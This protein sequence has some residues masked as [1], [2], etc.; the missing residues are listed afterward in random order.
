MDPVNEIAAALAAAQAEMQNPGFDSTNPHFK[1]KFASLAAVRKSVVPVFA[2]HGISV[3]QALTTR[4]AVEKD[5]IF[6]DEKVVDGVVVM[7]G[8]KPLYERSFHDVNVCWV[9]CVVTLYHASGQSIAFPPFEAPAGDMTAQGV[10]AASTYLRRY[11]LQSIAGVV[12]DDDTDGNDAQPPP[13]ASTYKAPGSPQ[14]RPAAAPAPVAQPAAKPAGVTTGPLKNWRGRDYQAWLSNTS[15]AQTAQGDISTEQVKELL[16]LGKA[17]NK[18]PAMLA[19]EIQTNWIEA[20]IA[21][22][23]PEVK[24]IW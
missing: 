20:L 23:C 18:S 13:R 7:H 19:R 14:P 4:T 21:A 8:G 3:T 5:V 6:F 9:G 22:G 10:A 1:S 17:L 16:A 24:E 11:S 12:G 15:D 2:K